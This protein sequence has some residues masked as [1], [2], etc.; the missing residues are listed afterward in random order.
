VKTK[1]TAEDAKALTVSLTPEEE[2]ALNA[3]IL[4]RRKRGD[5]RDSRNGVVADAVWHYLLTVEKVSREQI[6]SLFPQKQEAETKSNIT[7]IRKMGDKIEP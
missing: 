5:E 2:M 3:V 4:R 6:E 7:T 1:K